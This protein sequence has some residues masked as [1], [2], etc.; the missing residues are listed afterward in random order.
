MSG[1]NNSPLFDHEAEAAAEK[2]LFA[3]GDAI[4]KEDETTLFG[5]ELSM[6]TLHT[7]QED[8]VRQCESFQE[9]LKERKQEK[10]ISR[11]RRFFQFA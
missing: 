4:T 3:E 7:I 5:I 10:E 6:Q 1:K 9:T 8:S 11:W 2:K